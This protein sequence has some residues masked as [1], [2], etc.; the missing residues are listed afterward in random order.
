M[1][2][3]TRHVAIVASNYWPEPTGVSQTVT[4]FAEFLVRS[5]A[6]VRVATGMPGS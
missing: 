6:D 4:E 3:W 2:A 1:S 5:G